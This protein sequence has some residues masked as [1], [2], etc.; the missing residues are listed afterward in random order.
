MWDKMRCVFGVFKENQDEVALLWRPY[1]LIENTV[2]SMHPQLWEQYKAL[3]EEHKQESWGIYDDTV[4]MDRAVI[5]SDG[6]YENH[7]S[8]VQLYQQT[9]KPVMIQNV[10]I[11]A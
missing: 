2:K 9:G 5:L 10:D 7:S 11:V 8:V 1:P 4:G 3:V 6:Y